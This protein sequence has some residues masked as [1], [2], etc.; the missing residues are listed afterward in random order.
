MTECLDEA[1]CLEIMIIGSAYSESEYDELVILHNRFVE[2]VLLN[3]V[4]RDGVIEV[5]KA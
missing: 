3:M 1:D 5:E 4:Y 2:N